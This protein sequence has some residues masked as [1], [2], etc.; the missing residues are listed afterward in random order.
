MPHTWVGSG[1]VEA[2]RTLFAYEREEDDAL[3]LAA[4][5]PRAWVD[6]DGGVG[7]R[8]LPTYYGVLSYRIDTAGPA[9]TR[10]IL[11]GDATRPPGGFVLMPPLPAPLR[12]ATINGRPVASTDGRSL[13]VDTLPADILMEH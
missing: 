11:S 5:L 2:V 4:G 8:R 9:L 3:V 10:M 12:G 6:R 13:V 1:F 7:V